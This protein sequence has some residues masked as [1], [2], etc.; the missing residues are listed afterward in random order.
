M[1]IH[2]ALLLVQE[3]G[4]P[5]VLEGLMTGE[6]LVT[7]ARTLLIVALGIPVSVGLSRW[8]KRVVSDRHGP[9]Q[10]LVAGKLVFYPLALVIAISAMTE[11]GFSLAPILGAAGIP[12]GAT[13][14]T[15]ELLHDPDLEAR[16]IFQTVQ[17][18]D[19][20][21]HKM[22]AWP[23]KM[24]DSNVPLAAAPLLGEHTEEVLGTWLD[25]DADAIARLRTDGAI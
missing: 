13:F 24:S 25:A 8:V 17:H 15:M 20:G 4:T 14:D 6:G 2:G 22:P 3:A 19:R 21:A 7:L 16:G 10:G 9:Q 23:V 12:A 18:P 11:L 5:S 1:P